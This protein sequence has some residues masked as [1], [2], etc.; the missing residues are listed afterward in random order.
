MGDL[1]RIRIFLVDT[2]PTTYD[3]S[4]EELI[5]RVATLEHY[6]RLG[7]RLVASPTELDLREIVVGS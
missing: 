4:I 2:Y 1:E 3:G 5:E 6:P 7:S